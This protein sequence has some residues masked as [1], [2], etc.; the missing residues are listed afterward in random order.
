MERA[1]VRFVIDSLRFMPAV[2]S[3][4]VAAPAPGEYERG[5]H[6]LVSGWTALIE[7]HY[8]VRPWTLGDDVALQ[9]GVNP[10][11]QTKKNS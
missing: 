1:R 3:L 9:N 5:G 7:G 8:D 2:P 4:P 11:R 6:G 10:W